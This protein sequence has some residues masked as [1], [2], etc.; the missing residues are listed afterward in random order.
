M[1]EPSD[2]TSKPI[3]SSYPLRTI[4]T[5]RKLTMTLLLGLGLGLT[6]T[7][8]TSPER[9]E[10]ILSAAGYEN[11]DITG[12]AMFSCSEDDTVKTGFRATG[13]HGERVTGAVCCGVFGK[14]CTIRIRSVE[15]RRQ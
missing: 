1:S 10:D 8:C 5:M 12:Y 9:S 14:N 13:A 2:D 3:T 4:P 7:A 6:T 15:H 11:I